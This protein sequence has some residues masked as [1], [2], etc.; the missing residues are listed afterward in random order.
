MS[1]EKEELHRFDPNHDA[2]STRIINS[3][4]LLKEFTHS[5][6]ESLRV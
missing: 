5:V 2:P 4:D 1:R 3:G 6:A